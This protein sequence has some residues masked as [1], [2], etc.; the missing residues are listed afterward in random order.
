LVATPIGNLADITLRALNIL[1]NVDILACEDT[2]VSRILLKHYDIHKKPISYHDHN[3]LQI[4]ARLLKALESG[5]SIA[6]ISDA[7]TPLISD[8]GFQLV[9]SARQANIRVIPIPGP[10]SVLTALIATGLPT[11]SFYFGGFLPSRQKARRR[12]LE[13]SKN[14]NTTLI[15]Y[16]SPYRLAESLADMVDIL[17]GDRPSALCRELT[18]KFETIHTETLAALFSAY[19][20]ENRTRGEIV[21]VIGSEKKKVLL[22]TENTDH[23]LYDLLLKMPSAQAAKKASRITGLAKK[24][25]YARI[26][27]LKAQQS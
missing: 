20:G 10:S 8:P 13:I 1:K 21:L 22:N 16:E 3:A 26:I 25:L 6:L 7:G 9:E 5:K 18:K 17:G 12:K 15:F 14:I 19:G 24:N 27:E 4:G 23:I 11:D 2:R